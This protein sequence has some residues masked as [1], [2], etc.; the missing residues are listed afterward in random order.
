MSRDQT[1]SFDPGAFLSHI[2]IGRTVSKYKKKQIIYS[3]GEP[4]D[5]VFYIQAGTVKLSAVC[6]LGKE[7]ILAILN[8]DDFFGEGCIVGQP[9]RLSTATA[10][11]SCSVMEIEKREI[12]RV[13]HEEHAFPDRFVSHLILRNLRLEADL[14]DQLFNSSEKRLARV[15]LLL[16]RFGKEGPPEIVIP[17]ISQETLAAMVGTTRSRINLFMNRFKKLGYIDYDGGLRVHSSLLTIV[18]H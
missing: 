2:A 11:T 1:S 7:A 5:A 6:A 3:Q 4:A 12:I 18:L 8:V 13:L 17:K 15:L 9:V 10:V 14:V 16:S